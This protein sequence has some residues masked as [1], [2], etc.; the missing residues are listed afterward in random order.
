MKV[1]ND[2]K[3]ILQAN[4]TESDGELQVGKGDGQAWLCR[5]QTEKERSFTGSAA[6]Q[7]ELSTCQVRVRGMA[8]NTTVLHRTQAGSIQ[9]AYDSTEAVHQLAD[10]MP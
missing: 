8:K 9:V 4:S 3:T 1:G 2:R 6:L 10:G 5:Y 7:N